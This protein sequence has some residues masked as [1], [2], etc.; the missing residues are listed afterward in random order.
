MES[1]WLKNL[2]IPFLRAW[3]DSG[4]LILLLFL[5]FLQYVLWKSIF[6]FDFKDDYNG[7]SLLKLVSICWE[8]IPGILAKME[9]ASIPSA[10]PT[11]LL[12]LTVRTTAE[13][14]LPAWV[15]CGMLAAAIQRQVRTFTGMV[16]TPKGKALTDWCHGSVPG[17]QW[18][19]QEHNS[20]SLKQT[21][22][23]PA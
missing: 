19:H 4:T 23:R 17:P 20:P 16:F 9:V 10:A 6:Y 11:L 18:E 7:D 14:H 3:G 22:V 13:R 12:S 1:L 2:E 21:Q 5:L 8:I 15:L